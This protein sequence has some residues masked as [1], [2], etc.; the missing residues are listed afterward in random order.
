MSPEISYWGGSSVQG[1]KVRKLNATSFKHLVERY[2]HAPVQIPLTRKEF[3]ALPDDKARDKVKDGPY[4]CAC[5]FAYESEGHRS[6]DKAVQVNLVILD[7][8]EG[9]WVKDFDENPDTLGEHLYPFNFACWRTAKHRDGKPRLKIVVEVVPCHPQHHRRLVSFIAARLGLPR[10]FK[11]S[12]ESKVTS[13]P[14]YRPVQFKGSEFDAVIASRVTGI[15]VHLADLPELDPEDEE[16]L[17]GRTYACDTSES[18]DDYFGLA[19]LPVADLTL[20]DIR[21]AMFSIDPDCGYKEWIEV[22]AS[23]RHQFT[24]EDDAREA[25]ELFVEWSSA[26]TKFIGRRDCWAKWKSFRPYAKGRAPVT[27]RTLY[28]HAMDAGWDNTKVARKIKQTVDEWLAACTDKDELMQEGA[29]KIASLPF[30]NEVVEESLVIAWRNRIKALTG[31]SINKT[32]LTKEIAKV[33]RADKQAKQDARGENLPP[34]LRPVVYVAVSDTFNNL[35]NGVALKP[36][37][38]DRYFEKE[39]MP[40]D[41]TPANG[42]PIM[43]PSAYALNIQKI[44]RV[45]DTIYDPTKGDEQIFPDP[46]TGKLYLNLYNPNS[47]P[48]ADPEH[49]AAAEALIYQLVSAL[50]AE[51]WLRE[52]AID[53]LALQAQFPGVKIPWSFLFQSAPGVGKGTLGEVMEA[54][55]G[56]VNVKIISPELMKA[57]FN[58]WARNAALGIFNEV[59]MPGDRRDQIMNAIKPLISDPTIAMNLKNRDGECRVRNVTNYI[60]FTNYKDACHI[61]DNDRRWCIV[62]SPYQTKSQ[63]QKLRD[64]GHFEQVRWLVTPEGASALRYF[65]EKRK[66]SEDFPFTGHAPETK[67][68]HEVIEQSKNTLQ[69]AI[70]ECIADAVDPLVGPLAVH[71]GRLRELVCRGTREYGF[72]PRFLSALGYERHGSRRIMVD[73]TRGVVWTHTENWNDGVTI[74]E[75]LRRRMKEAPSLDDEETLFE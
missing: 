57:S 65:L 3:W 22:A 61:A 50:I 41:E 58:D 55:M 6:D 35:G 14:Q 73:G 68:R 24:D 38:F 53:Y 9:E 66:V 69:V 70:E 45:E 37:A 42:K 7:L 27:I 71:E 26:G 2:I 11:G 56:A 64:S 46:E 1:G 74:E 72:L 31:E 29:K 40:K 33:R 16:M 12:R 49:A 47:V 34:W 43:S 21:E 59:Y 51:P 60:A 48:V 28:K 36:G 5:S 75:Y 44:L 32:T 52:L 54:V 62:Y 18:E 20:E 15:P 19:F 67:Y 17:E 39:L 10:N 23:L 25:Y 30:K 63:V 13:Q 4:V 8:D